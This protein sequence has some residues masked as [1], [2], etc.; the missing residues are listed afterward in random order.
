MLQFVGNNRL[1]RLTVYVGKSPK[2]PIMDIFNSGQYELIPYTEGPNGTKIGVPYCALRFRLIDFWTVK[3]LLV[4]GNIV[5][6]YAQNLASIISGDYMKILKRDQP[7]K[8]LY[9]GKFE[10]AEIA[11][12]RQGKFVQPPIFPVKLNK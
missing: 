8:Y 2:T 4:Q 11:V 1:K 9:V 6:G 5:H 10:D 12:K 7:D 3:V